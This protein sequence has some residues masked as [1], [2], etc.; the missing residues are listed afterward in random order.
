MAFFDDVDV[1]I[2]NL[3]NTGAGKAKDM[4]ESFRISGAIREEEKKQEDLYKQIGQY[5]YE[6]YC[7][8]AEGQLRVWCS[9]IKASKVQVLQYQDQLNKL[10]GTITCPGCGA[11][12]A[13]GSAFCSGCG[14]KM[15]P[16]NRINPMNKAGR[17]CPACG[18]TVDQDSMFC[19]NCGQRMP[20]LIAAEE[21]NN[22][23][24]VEKKQKVC[25]VCGATVEED[26]VF[27][28]SCG[29]RIPEQE[30]VT[31]V[32]SS[33]DNQKL[34]PTC[35]ATVEKD[36]IFCT[37]CGTKIEKNQSDI[38]ENENFSEPLDNAFEEVDFSSLQ[39]NESELQ[40][41]AEKREICPACGRELKPGQKFCTNCGTKIEA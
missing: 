31:D 36:Q 3:I 32:D 13:S 16:Q 33:E 15:Q 12:V 34:C 21:V 22:D 8:S 27:C 9:G 29:Q 7:D 4:S 14:M 26:Q 20:E 17:R 39:E 38:S 5:Y 40:T 19:T 1:K 30:E 25:P 6:N 11:E 24:T 18:N 35:G 10:K 23:E 2:S 37:K 41:E 28:T